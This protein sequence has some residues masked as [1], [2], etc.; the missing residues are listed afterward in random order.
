[1]TDL[2]G[3]QIAAKQLA[4]EGIDTV[5]GVVAGPMLQLFGALPNEGIRY[6]G[7]RHEEAACFMAQAW[8]YITKKPGVVI[9]GS[10]P[11]ML[12]TVT[13]LHVAQDNGWP[14]IVLGGSTGSRLRGLG[15]FQETN[16][17]A[18]AA[19]FCKWV[20][21]VASTDRIPEFIHLAAG[22][23]LSGR[24]GAVYLDF[25]GQIPAGRVPEERVQ[26]LPQGAPVRP[27]RPDPADVEAI[28]SLLAG[29]ERPLVLIGKG[30][31]WADAAGPLTR[32]AGLGIPF[33]ASPMGRGTVPDDHPLC[34]GAARST[35]LANADAILMVGGRFNWIFQFGR[36]P[37]FAP[38]VRIAHVD[39]VPEELFSAAPVEI[40]VAADCTATVEALNEALAERPLRVAESGWV[41]RLRETCEQNEQQTAGMLNAE[42]KPIHPFRLWREVRDTVERD[43]TIAVDGESILGIG[44]I[45]M[46]SFLPRHR[47]NSG[48]T[49][50]MGTGVAYAIGA[51]LARPDKQVV[52]V[53]G[54]YAFGASGMEVET[55][56]RVG[57]PVVF[58]ISNNQG[59]V[60]SVI[61]D[62]LQK[63]GPP[64]STLLPASY[65]K[66]AEMVGGYGE[67]VTEPDEIGPA[68]RRALASGKVAIV[69]VMTDPHGTAKSGGYLTGA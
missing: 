58:V 67:Q 21:Q 9:A 55:A 24:P 52:A 10:G 18:G 57:A 4:A 29:A 64:L 40:G 60:G 5:F 49:G 17:V 50:C 8:G 22:K 3:G 37:R 16:Q 30:A 27:A 48:T 56:A 62:Q 26:I 36:P 28:A 45:A 38:D 25:P 51:K 7:C 12:N 1:M 68:V 23:A 33:V 61:Q 43:V 53:L 15:G 47:L 39:I 59:I 65:E 6:V 46:P 31:A 54:D 63:G 20:Q 32:L 42:A 34:V 19:P 44:R 14:L 69:N 41:E 66:M 13:G 11:G 35:A 2:N